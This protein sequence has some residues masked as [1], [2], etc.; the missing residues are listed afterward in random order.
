MFLS[1]GCTGSQTA[2][3]CGV[4]VCSGWGVCAAVRSLSL[5]EL[6]NVTDDVSCVLCGWLAANK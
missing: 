4:C 3:G 2:R 5:G 6:F 1:A